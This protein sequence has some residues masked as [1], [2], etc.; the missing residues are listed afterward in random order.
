VLR[1]AILASGRGTT[2]E[3]VIAAC[4]SGRIAGEV[5]IVIGNNSKVQ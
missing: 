4:Q 5:V 2:A 1:I 3:A